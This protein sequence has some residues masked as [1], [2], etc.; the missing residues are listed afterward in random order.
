MQADCTSSSASHVELSFKDEYLTRSDM[1]RL[2]VGELSNK[3]VFQGQKL[4]FMGTVK[5][6]VN[7]VYLDGRKVQSAFFSTN[8]KPIFRSESARYVLFIQMS[9]EM[10]DFDSEGSGEIMFNKVVNGFLPTL[11]KKW[12]ALKAKHLVSIVL[13]TRV[14]Y[15]TG[16]TSELAA[17]VHDSEYLTGIQVDGNK[18]PYKDFYRVVVSEMASGSWT[19]ILYTLKREFKFFRKDISLHRIDT[20]SGSEAQPENGRRGVLGTRIEAEP[21]LAMYGNVLEAINLASSQFS[22]DY[23]DRDLMR[24]GISVVVITPSPG[25]FEVDYETL[26]T[27]TEILIG[28]GIGIDLVCLPKMPLHSV[29]LFRYRNPQYASF[30]EGLHFRSL[31]SEDSTPRQTTALFGSSFSSLNDSLSP[32]KASFPDRSVHA[33]PVVTTNTPSEWSYAIPHWIDVS[34]WTGASQDHFFSNPSTKGVKRYLQKFKNQQSTNFGTR[35]KMY[36]MEMASLM[37]NVMNEISVTPLQH[38]PLFPQMIIGSR[39]VPLASVEIKDDFHILDYCNRY[40]AYSSLLEFV[41]GPSKSLIDRDST[42]DDRGFY[43]TL[44]AFDSLR[45]E[46]QGEYPGTRH[47]SEGKKYFKTG[48]EE[49]ARRVLADD[50]KVFGTSF[51]DEHTTP[52]GA[53]LDRKSV[54]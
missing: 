16:L 15:D 35:C 32:P 27:T 52:K 11:F 21:S 37:D 42:Q 31:R 4:L 2:A 19:T 43:K 13:F 44:S 54:V 30:Q 50:P 51:S 10:W 45:S 33:G 36:E 7:C 38:D 53:S 5:A 48:S 39:E 28:N 24:T 6:Q 25:L 46:I 9:K 23:I 40:R 14:E 17:T 22:H 1:W 41:G 8:T 29:P 20:T 47:K 12:A 18:K 3:T 34:F 26:R 49:G